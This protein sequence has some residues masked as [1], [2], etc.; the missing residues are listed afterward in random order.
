M[1]VGPYSF[2][3]DFKTCLAVFWTDTAPTDHVIWPAE[4]NISSAGYV[5][6]KMCSQVIPVIKLGQISSL[7]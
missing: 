7:Y 5:A 4:R 2:E 3:Q 1:R 6:G